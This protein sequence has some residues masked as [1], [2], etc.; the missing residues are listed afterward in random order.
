MKE[1]YGEG[2]AS[3]CPYRK[4]YP[5]RTPLKSTTFKNR[6]LGP[7]ESGHCNVTR[8]ITL[9]LAHRINSPGTGYKG[10]ASNMRYARL[11]GP[12]CIFGK[13][14]QAIAITPWSNAA[15]PSWI[16][17]VGDCAWDLGATVQP[18][19]LTPRAAQRTIP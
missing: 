3:H 5:A 6:K 8:Y 2:L 9:K 18:L 19:P 15:R 11:K 10:K 13:H 1:P 17:T 16:V 12:D 7:R 4:H 14:R